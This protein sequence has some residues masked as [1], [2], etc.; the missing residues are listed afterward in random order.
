MTHADAIAAEYG[1]YVAAEDI[2]IAGGRAFNAGDPVPVSHVTRGVVTAEQVRDTAPEP[3]KAG[4]STPD[5]TK[6]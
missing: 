3:T 6:G 1:R 2:F 5:E 4:R